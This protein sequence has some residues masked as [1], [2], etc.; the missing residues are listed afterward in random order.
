MAA[1]EVVVGDLEG[2]H[3]LLPDGVVGGA[4]E[5]DSLL[6]CRSVVV[7]HCLEPVAVFLQVQR[8]TG[9]VLASGGAQVGGV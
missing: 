1:G 3:W 6:D 4:V 8:S 9:F 7:V 2:A 5:L